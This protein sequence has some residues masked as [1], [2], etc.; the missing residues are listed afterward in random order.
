MPMR[1]SMLV[2]L[3]ALAAGMA[4]A[5]DKRISLPT[6]DT[7]AIASWREGWVVGTPPD[8]APPGSVVFHGGDPKKWRATIAPLAAHPTLT[9]DVGNL[10]IYV[11][12]LGRA[13]ENGGLEVDHEQK[14]VDAASPRGFY[15]KA[16]DPNPE[17]HAKSKDEAYAD[18]YTG[19][20]TVGS[21][22]YLFEITWNKGGEADA[23]AALAVMKTLR[24]L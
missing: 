2:L 4:H 3:V 7:L 13:L 16:H 23:N 11:R 15:V 14:P 22:P 19:A 18:G 17:L 21:K 9:G 6:G 1:A 10:R 8:E 12:N 5:A 24:V 20:I